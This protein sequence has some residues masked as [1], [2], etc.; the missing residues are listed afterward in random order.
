[1]SYH[2][3]KYDKKDREN[4]RK[5]CHL[6]ATD[7]AYVD[8]PELVATISA[9]YCVAYEPDG[10][11]IVARDE[12]D[13]AVGY[14]LSSVDYK[15]FLKT[16]DKNIMPKVRKMSRLQAFTHWFS[17]RQSLIDAKKYPAHLH[18][19]IL[20]EAQG[21][22]YGTALM[23][24]LMKYLNEKGVKGVHLGVGGDNEGGIAFYKKYGFKMIHDFGKTGK[25]F[26]IRPSDAVKERNLL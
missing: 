6:T 4:V 14:I 2:I 26:A 16:F 1:M 19:D 22:G 17:F 3:R 12:D 7:P 15:T 13:E 20:P 18:I 21:K 24:E 8:N 25:V 23:D 9:D 11:F 5:I 10:V